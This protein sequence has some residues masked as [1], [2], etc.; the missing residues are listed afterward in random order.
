VF[1]SAISL[2]PMYKLSGSRD[3]RLAENFLEMSKNEFAENIGG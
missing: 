3:G 2:V 1:E